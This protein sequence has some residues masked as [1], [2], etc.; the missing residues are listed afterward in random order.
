MG[1]RLPFRSY[2]GPIRFPYRIKK[3]KPRMITDYHAKYFAHELSRRHSAADSEKL[4]GAGIKFCPCHVKG[5]N[6][7]KSTGQAA[8]P[9]PSQLLFA[10][11]NLLYIPP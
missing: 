3:E 6:D 9:E 4:A 7:Y 2:V 1:V 11:R 10:I 5:T 8:R